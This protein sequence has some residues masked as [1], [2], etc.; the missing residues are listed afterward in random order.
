MC[1]V[2][3]IS[4]QCKHDDAYKEAD[5]LQRVQRKSRTV[6]TMKKECKMEREREGGGAERERV[7]QGENER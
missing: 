1:A 5:L 4:A 3:I 6:L 7:R 2:K